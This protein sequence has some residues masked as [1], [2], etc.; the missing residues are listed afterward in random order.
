MENFRNFPCGPDPFGRTW[1][2]FFKWLQTAISI[3]HSDSVDVKFIL[4]CGEE[5]QEKTISMP[6][7][8][9]VTLAASLGVRMTDAWCSRLA[10]Q[11]VEHLILSGED[12]EKELVTPSA[13]HLHAYAE[14]EKRWEVEE[15]RKRRGAA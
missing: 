13:E 1:R 7:Y 12:M 2:V 5:T 9:L 3:R 11:H 14:N 15:V 4:E 8:T 10:K 6:H